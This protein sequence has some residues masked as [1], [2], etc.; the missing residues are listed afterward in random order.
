MAPDFLLPAMFVAFLPKG[1]HRPDAR[2]VLHVSVHKTFRTAFWSVPVHLS[3]DGHKIY[4]RG[5]FDDVLEKGET[6]SDTRDN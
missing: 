1:G 6:R 4:R 3:L 2:V 5:R